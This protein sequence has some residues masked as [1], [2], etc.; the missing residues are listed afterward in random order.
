MLQKIWFFAICKKSVLQIW[1]QILNTATKTGLDIS[2]TASKNVIH[3]TVKRT[4]EFMGNKSAKKI[5]KPQPMLNANWRKKIFHHIEMR[6]NTERIKK[7]Y[8]LVKYYK[9]SKLLEH[10][11]V[12]KYVTRK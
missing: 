11:T 7:Y 2:K 6:H 9:I 4:S 10:L 5:V 1:K 8:K 12:L 3:K